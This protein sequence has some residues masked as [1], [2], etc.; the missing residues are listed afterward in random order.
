MNP[1][2]KEELLALKN[3]GPKSVAQ[4]VDIGIT[5][6]D[7]LIELGTEEVFRRLYF[8]FCDEQ[9]LSVNYLYAL[10][11]AIIGC[12]WRLIPMDRKQ[13][14]KNLLKGLKS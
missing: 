2:S 12:D 3:L 8:R 1:A 10:E 13:E 4:L 14:L 11:G 9:R 7:Q 6:S 5:S